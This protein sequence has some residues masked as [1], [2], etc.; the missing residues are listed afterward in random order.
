MRKFII[1]LTMTLALSGCSG[2][3]VK[4]VQDQA[5]ALCGK[6]PAY[7]SVAEMIAVAVSDQVPAG[8]VLVKGTNAIASAICASFDS[9]RS[10]GMNTLLSTCAGRVNGVCVQE[11]EKAPAP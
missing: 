9:A 7:A 8:I 6:W 2:N 11:E 1:A 10:S 3:Q 4:A 5:Y